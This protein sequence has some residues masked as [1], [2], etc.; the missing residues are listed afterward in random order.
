[1]QCATTRGGVTTTNSEEI[2]VSGG[3]FNYPY[4]TFEHDGIKRV[5]YQ[6]SRSARRTHSST[7]A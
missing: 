3:S 6:C 1:M 5:K 7:A 2:T 4:Y